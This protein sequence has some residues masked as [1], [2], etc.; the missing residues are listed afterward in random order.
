[1]ILILT[2]PVHSGKTSFLQKLVLEVKEQGCRVDGYL[3]IAIFKDKELIGYDL[4]DL[5]D[6]KASPFLRRD[7]AMSWEKVG[8]YF[9]VPKA[10]EQAKRKI[11]NHSSKDF[12]FVD[13]L[14]PLEIQG[15]GIWPALQEI[16]SRPS[17][18]CL[19]V[20]RS[21][22]LEDF[23]NLTK[24]I[25]SQ[26]FGIESQDNLALL[27][28]EIQKAARIKKGRFSQAAVREE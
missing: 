25:P 15:G 8:P 16:F 26:V 1:M 11:I 10:L 23:E 13:E 12:L 9:F 20:V 5:K 28:K 7:G 19:L 2:G 14:G 17:L 4:F 27:R 24:G 3:S 21:N 6:E 22:I 18:R